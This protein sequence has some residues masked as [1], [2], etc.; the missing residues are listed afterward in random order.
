[1]TPPDLTATASA[2]SNWWSS[3]LPVRG[4]RFPHD[5][6]E[7]IVRRSHRR[8]HDG[9][10]GGEE[11]RPGGVVTILPEEVAAAV[12]EG[13]LEPAQTPSGRSCL[14]PHRRYDAITAGFILASAVTSC[15]KADSCAT[16]R[17]HQP[18]ASYRVGAVACGGCPTARRRCRSTTTRCRGGVAAGMSAESPAVTSVTNPCGV[19]VAASATASPASGLRP[20][21]PSAG[22]GINRPRTQPLPKLSTPTVG[23][24]WPPWW[25]KWPLP[26]FTK[27]NLR[28][29]A[30]PPGDDGLD[31][32]RLRGVRRPGL[33]Q[34]GRK[35]GDI[36]KRGPT[37][38]EMED[39]RC[40]TVCRHE[41]QCDR[42][43]Q[44]RSGDRSRCRG[45]EP[46]G[47][48]PTGG[49]PRRRPGPWGGGGFGRL[50]PVRRR[51][52]D[53][54]RSGGDRRRRAGRRTPRRRG[55]RCSRPAR[56][57][58]RVHRKTPL[59]PL[60]PRFVLESLG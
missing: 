37:D 14:L 9:A 51:P 35:M 3:T 54:G 29:A 44:G 19:A 57:G 5:A 59:P 13:G 12:A 15:L 16:A 6:T 25:T 50:L 33:R 26:S 20:A 17:T 56:S 60:K 48:C 1:M 53:P 52:R 10:S 39:L 4:D 55:H 21:W 42:G 49:R 40:L 45:P 2:L 31:L 7:A 58:A 38:T 47:C 28:V 18:G 36:S 22:G 34:P 27:P 43:R 23:W 41:V 30:E 24:W 46:R 32:R 8:P 11:P